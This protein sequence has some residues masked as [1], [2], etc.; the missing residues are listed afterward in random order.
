MGEQS[1]NANLRDLSGMARHTVTLKSPIDG[2][3]EEI[4]LAA[5]IGPDFLEAKDFIVKERTQKAGRNMASI[6]APD[7]LAMHVACVGERAEKQTSV[8]LDLD[9]VTYMNFIMARRAGYKG[10][11]GTFRASLQGSDIRKLQDALLDLCGFPK[12]GSAPSAN[13]TVG[14]TIDS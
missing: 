6:L 10:D 12:M 5:P 1:N 4:P 7:V 9:G 11:W 2:R 8:L 3:V 13:P 14:G